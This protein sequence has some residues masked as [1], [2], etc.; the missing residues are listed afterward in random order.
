VDGDADGEELGADD[1]GAAVSWNGESVDC[2][3][4]GVDVDAIVGTNVGT[5]I[6]SALARKVVTDVGA[7]V[8]NVEAVGAAAG[9]VEGDKGAK[10]VGVT[11]AA[12]TAIGADDGAATGVS[13]TGAFAGPAVGDAVVT[14]NAASGTSTGDIVVRALVADTAVV[15][16]SVGEA[17]RASVGG[18]LLGDL[19]G[20][21]VGSSVFCSEHKL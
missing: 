7:W 6:D 14:G 19:V 3:V 1:C 21:N 5:N 9:E 10:V 15:G 20:T 13:D 18:A 12:E 11:G 8:T 2:D 17:T 16:A 4:V